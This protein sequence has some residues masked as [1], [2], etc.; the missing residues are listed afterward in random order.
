M[1]S[2]RENT[3]SAVLLGKNRLQVNAIPAG[4]FYL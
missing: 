4:G 2:E 3:S 1:K